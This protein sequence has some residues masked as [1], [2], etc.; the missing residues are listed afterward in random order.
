VTLDTTILVDDETIADE[1][2]RPSWRGQIH[3]YAAILFVPAFAVLVGLARTAT[4]RFAMVVYGMGVVTMLGVSAVYHSGRLGPAGK[5]RLKRVDH[6]TILFG[7]TGSYTGICTLALNGSAEVTML[8]FV[9]SA[10][11]V[12]IVIRMCWLHAPRWVTAAVYMVVGWSALIEI[13]PL[14]RSLAAGDTALM[15]AG[16]GLYSLGAAVYATKRPNWS[17][18]HFGFHEVF[19]ALVV[20]AAVLHYILVV[21][22]LAGA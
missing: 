20:A 7:V 8:V 15:M 12:G 1:E 16:G 10:A 18:K 4:T 14:M 21:R 13:S 5:A 17:P 22:L 6:S 19:H 3:R 9:W 2:L 11:A